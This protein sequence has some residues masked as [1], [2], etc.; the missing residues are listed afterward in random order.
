MIRIAD[1]KPTPDPFA[2]TGREH[3]YSGPYSRIP[4]THN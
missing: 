2:Y 1:P 4:G 3:L